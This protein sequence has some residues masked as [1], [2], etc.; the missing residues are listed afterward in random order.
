MKSSSDRI[1]FCSRKAHTSP[2]RKSSHG[3][4]SG[5]AEVGEVAGKAPVLDAFEAA[6]VTSFADGMIS[7]AEASTLSLPLSGADG[8]LPMK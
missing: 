3:F 6:S 2:G 8:F 4:D 1:L 5:P 7:E